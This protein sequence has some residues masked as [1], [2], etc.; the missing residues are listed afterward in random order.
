MK[1]GKSTYLILI[2][3]IFAI[4]MVAIYSAGNRYTAEQTD[5]RQSLS[6]AQASLPP[7]VSQQAAL[8]TQLTEQQAL[9][10]EQQVLLAK[11]QSAL[12]Q[13]Q[14]LFPQDIQSVD[15]ADTL[16]TLAQ[17]NKLEISSIKA[18]EP[19][20]EKIKTVTYQTTLVEVE[21]RAAAPR[22]TTVDEYKQYIDDTVFH[23]LK[24]VDSIVRT[25]QF[26]T[27]T[28]DTVDMK[29]LQPPTEETIESAEKPLAVV[30][31]YVF[32]YGGE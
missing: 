31:L 14:A 25:A 12:S 28:M 32:A 16:T 21:V 13:A 4:A 17:Q 9:L 20:V 24:F 6:A 3:G 11:A 29:N 15:Y 18:A 27:V 30:K 2:I 22:P 8:D 1:I 23:I 7:L 19:T 5:I 26:N 10:K